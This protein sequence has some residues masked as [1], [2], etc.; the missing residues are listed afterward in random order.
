MVAIL[1]SGDEPTHL[2]ER[3]FPKVLL[4]TVITLGVYG[5]YW[6][7]SVNK[8]LKLEYDEEYNPLWRTLA[9]LIPIYDILVFWRISDT[10]AEHVV[11]DLNGPVLF[12]FW[13]VF[14]PAAIYLIQDGIN[15][16][17]QE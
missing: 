2:I 12:L 15:Q 13:I 10:A 7:Y 9:L 11:E 4:Y 1:S 8:Q 17:V 5:F 3:S 16:K 6:L 14:F